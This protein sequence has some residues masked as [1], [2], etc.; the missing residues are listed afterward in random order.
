[1]SELDDLLNS[2]TEDTTP[3]AES[4]PVTVTASDDVNIEDLLADAEATEATE[5]TQPAAVAET[6]PAATTAAPGELDLDALLTDL[7]AEITPDSEVP[8]AAPAETVAAPV[9]EKPSG[10]GGGGKKDAPEGEEATEV[11]ADAESVK[12]ERQ[13]RIFF[14]KKTDRIRHKLGDKIAEYTLRE[15][16][17]GELTE[18]L[19]EAEKNATLAAIDALGVKPQQRAA[20]IIEFVAGKSA[21]LNSVIADAFKLLHK[22]GKVEM[23]ADGNLWKLLSARYRAGS[24]RAM[25][26]NTLIAMKALKV[27]N[28]DGKTLNQNSLIYPIVIEKL[29]L[30][31]EDQVEGQKAA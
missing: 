31:T 22:E 14:A 23:G 15:L 6:V 28:D 13:A 3:T 20:L 11:K 5:A 30:T 10:Q 2:L 12:K 21:T 1:M 27:L 29:G 24:A 25:G 9:A 18:E 7:T 4:A 19:I 17:E 16:P 8:A 26:G